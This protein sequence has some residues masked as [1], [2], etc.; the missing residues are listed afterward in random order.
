MPLQFTCYKNIFDVCTNLVLVNMSISFILIYV[1]AEN[2]IMFHYENLP[3][4]HTEIFSEEKN[5]NFIEKK[6]TNKQKF[7]KTPQTYEQD[8]KDY[9]SVYLHSRL[10]HAQRI[11]VFIM[12]TCPCNIQRFFK[13]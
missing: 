12:K 2:I 10:L 8:A 11:S 13:L 3:M 1:F 4:Q 7:L 6:K 9:M 5:E